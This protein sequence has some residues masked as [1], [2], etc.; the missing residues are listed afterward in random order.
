MCRRVGR[1]AG[2]CLRNQLD[3]ERWR[4]A[5]QGDDA[6]EMQGVDALRVPRQRLAIERLGFVQPPGA[7]VLQAQGDGF[8]AGHPSSARILPQSFGNRFSLPAMSSSMWE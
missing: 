3:R 7:V 1:A 2:E 5:L 6:E 4:A 8:G